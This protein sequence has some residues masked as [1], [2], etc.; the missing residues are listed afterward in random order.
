MSGSLHRDFTP[1]CTL[2]HRT[3]PLA[4]LAPRGM[5]TNT[6]PTGSCPVMQRMDEIT[7]HRRVSEA[8]VRIRSTD[9]ATLRDQTEL[10]EIPAPPFG[11]SMR[12]QAMAKR[13]GEAGLSNIRADAVGNV[14]A[15]RNGS[16]DSAP[17]VLTAHL[18]T[19]FPEGTDVTVTRKGDT[20]SGPGISD[21]ARGLAAQ[22]TLRF[23]SLP[24]PRSDQSREAFPIHRTTT[25]YRRSANDGDGPGS[26]RCSRQQQCAQAPSL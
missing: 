1:T 25:S 20:L 16:T 26:A 10:S 7:A 22:R 24:S 5:E 4:P 11:E 13:L 15:E 14:L 19:V 12:A 8:V 21:D 9:E 6:Q 18:D 23:S 2:W 3:E 17:L